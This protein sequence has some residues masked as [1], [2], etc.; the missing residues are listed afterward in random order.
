MVDDPH[1]HS[2]TVSKPAYGASVCVRSCHYKCSRC[3]FPAWPLPAPDTSRA[4]CARRG[5][6]ESC[7]L[8]PRPGSTTKSS[9]FSY[10]RPFFCKIYHPLVLANFR[11]LAKKVLASAKSSFSPF[12]R[13]F[14]L[15]SVITCP[16][17]A[18]SFS[19]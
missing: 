10:L 6:K 13:W 16:R 18:A 9:R 11:Q 5:N 19:T 14:F 7:R 12:I 1:T 15:S 2:P 4:G 8:I 17:N 3:G